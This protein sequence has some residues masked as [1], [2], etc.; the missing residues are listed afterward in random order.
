MLS[1]YSLYSWYGVIKDTD[2]R[3]VMCYMYDTNGK[4]YMK[5]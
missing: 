3:Y 2:Y 4:D 1:Y 5:R